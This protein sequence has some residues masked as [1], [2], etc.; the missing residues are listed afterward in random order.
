LFKQRDIDNDG[1][2]SRDEVPGTL[3]DRLDAN[4]DG[5]VT[6]EEARALWKAR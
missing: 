5:F 2:L 1:K 6:E 3:F 4:K